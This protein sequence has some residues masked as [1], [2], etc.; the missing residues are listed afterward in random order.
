MSIEDLEKELNSQK[1]QTLYLFYGEELFLLD[2]AV[3]KIK[4]LEIKTM[5][6]P[7]FPTDLQSI[8]VSTLTISKGTSLIVENIFEN[9]YKFVPELIRMGAK[10]TIEGSDL[11]RDNLIEMIKSNKNYKNN[12][13]DDKYKSTDRKIYDRLV[14]LDKKLLVN[15]DKI[16]YHQFMKILKKVIDDSHNK[17]NNFIRRFLDYVQYEE[18]N[19]DLLISFSYRRT[20]LPPINHP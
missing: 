18:A 17:K 6:Y 9:R 19:A 15:F 12:L 4:A 5:P 16:P 2:S 10:I 13:F 11:T 14:N 20:K 3:K 1:L 7:G 8:F